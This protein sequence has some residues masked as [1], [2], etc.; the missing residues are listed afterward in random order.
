MRVKFG[1]YKKPL[2]CLPQNRKQCVY[3]GKEMMVPDGSVRL[4]HGECRTKGRK[5]Y[6][7]SN[8]QS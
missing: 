3:C 7:S 5:I 1:T 8:I 6:A 4:F 2:Q